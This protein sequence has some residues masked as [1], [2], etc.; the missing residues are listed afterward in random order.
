MP[1]RA[2]PFPLTRSSQ[3]RRRGGLAGGSVA[4]SC[5]LQVV[6]GPQDSTPP[7]LHPLQATS[8]ARLA[9][10]WGR[11]DFEGPRKEGARG[12]P[13]RRERRLGEGG[14]TGNE[15]REEGAAG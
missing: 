10:C 13:G 12:S 7:P 8:L 3:F 5:H 6:P 14:E 4:G 15:G 11:T 1:G 9:R 2:A